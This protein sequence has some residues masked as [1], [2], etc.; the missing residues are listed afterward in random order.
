MQTQHLLCSQLV[1]YVRRQGPCSRTAIA[2]EL[3]IGEPTASRLVRDLLAREVLVQDGFETSSGGRRRERVRLNPATA[4]A[5]GIHVAMR[6]VRGALIDLAGETLASEVGDDVTGNSVA[7]T[8]EAITRTI[9]RLAG[10]ASGRRLCGAAIGISGII[11]E[12]GQVSRE[13]TQAERWH[14]VPVADIVE[15]QSGLRALLLNDVHAAALGELQMGNIR[16]VRNLVYLH[17][18]DGIAAGIVANGALCRGATLNA[19]EIG[20]LIVE[21]NGPICYC[22]NR[23]CLESLASPRAVVE[24]CRNAAAMGVRTLALDHA[25]SPDAIAFDHILAAAAQGDRLTTNL[26]TDAGR[27]LGQVAANL[28]NVFD[29]E[30]LMLGGLLAGPRNVL[31]ETLER[32]TRARILPV[33][34]DAT[35]I[36]VSQ[37]KD[38]ASMLGAG[39]LVLDELFGDPAR[40]LE[41]CR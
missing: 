17:L 35:R 23:G 36:E 25:A 2:L 8:I 22:G 19:G 16:G 39:A 33:M 9:K 29:P 40:L 12:H 18:G 37:L 41:W 30:V 14:N 28:I 10:A 24:A 31:V 34:R 7:E 5:I 15:Q 21:E 11:H 4:C 3:G 13:F 26:L 38:S 20:H 1:N 32:T 6:R 27:R